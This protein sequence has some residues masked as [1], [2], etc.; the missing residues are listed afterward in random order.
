MPADAAPTTWT[1]QQLLA[2]TTKHFAGKNIDQP[3][4]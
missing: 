1:V 3:S 4:V 2:W